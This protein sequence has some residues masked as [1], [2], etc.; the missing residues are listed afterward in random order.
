M[1][2]ASKLA[3]N[4]EDAKDGTTLAIGKVGIDNG[5]GKVGEVGGFHRP[6]EPIA[7]CVICVKSGTK[8][9]IQNINARLR[10]RFGL[11]TTAVAEFVETPEWHREDQLVFENGRIVPLADFAN[12]GVTAFVG[13]KEV[14]DTDPVN[15]VEHDR[16]A[17]RSRSD[18]LATRHDKY[19]EFA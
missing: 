6:N 1:C 5:I 13:I 19:R 15:L 9:T 18:V 4:A 11:D 8:L 2:G 16:P 12:Q 17:V 14:A 3:A 10:D 7:A